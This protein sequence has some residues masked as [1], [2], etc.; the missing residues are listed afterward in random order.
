MTAPVKNRWLSSEAGS[1]SKMKLLLQ[2]I[3][4]LKV[5]ELLK[6]MEARAIIKRSAVMSDQNN[7]VAK[8]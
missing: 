4:G 1:A 3:L 7:P 6:V 5:Y 2:I 8:N